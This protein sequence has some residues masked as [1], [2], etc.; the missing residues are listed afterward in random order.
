MIAVL[1]PDAPPST[2]IAITHMRDAEQ[3]DRGKSVWCE[4]MPTAE[5]GKRRSWSFYRCAG[6]NRVPASSSPYRC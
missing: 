5:A 6:A 2:Y 3:V 4:G 1:R